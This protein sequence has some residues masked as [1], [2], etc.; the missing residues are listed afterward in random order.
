MTWFSNEHRM[1]EREGGY[2]FLEM[3]AVLGLLALVLSLSFPAGKSTSRQG[4]ESQASQISAR[5]K[6]ARV[7]AIS[8]NTEVTLEVDLAKRR[9]TIS[10][11]EQPLDL[12]EDIALTMLTARDEVQRG[13][14]AIRFFPDGT[15]TGGSLSL[16]LGNRTAVVGV[17]WL[18]GK[19]SRET[20]P[21]R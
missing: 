8:R 1:L 9:I 2:T 20:L 11:G 17:N 15:S 14:G 16:R 4:L 3:L 10:G 12:S 7:L 18:T 19:I 5:L 6:A 21:V 13:R